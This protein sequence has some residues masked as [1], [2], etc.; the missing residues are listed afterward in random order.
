M[1][2]HL[3][4]AESEIRRLF[5]SNNME[6]TA[7]YAIELYGPE[8]LGFLVATLKSKPDAEDVFAELCED[9]WRGIQKFAWRCSFRTWF[10]T[11]ARHATARF[12]RSPHRARGRCVPLSAAE[13]IANHVRTTTLAHLR[14]EVKDDFSRLRNRLDLE[15]QSL[16]IL[17][18]DRNMS[19]ND[20]AVVMSLNADLGKR[21]L[22][23]ISARLRKRFQS[24]KENLRR[25]AIEEGILDGASR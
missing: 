4:Y 10:Y 11:L 16:L 24:I 15:D 5:K 25:Y 7:T 19:W 9:A 2:T 21:D 14:T 22:A 1:S 17:R 20:I 6:A 18:V 23:R 3:A 12:L 13:E 8:V